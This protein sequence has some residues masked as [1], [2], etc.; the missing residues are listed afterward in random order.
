MINGSN[1]DAYKSLPKY[2]EDLGRNNPGSEIVL[3]TIDEEGVN[4]FSRMFG[5]YEATAKDLNT[6]AQ[7]LDSIELL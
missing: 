5:C 3:E 1:E 4:R 7:Y 6:V 2:C